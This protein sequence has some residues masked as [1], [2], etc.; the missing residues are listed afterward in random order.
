MKKN[1]FTLFCCFFA[2]WSFAC[3]DPMPAFYH[4]EPLTANS[5]FLIQPSG[6]HLNKYIR[7]D[8]YS[9]TTGK[10]IVIETT[11]HQQPNW[12][13][14]QILVQPT[15]SLILGDSLAFMM[16]YDTTITAFQTEA[17]DIKQRIRQAMINEHKGYYF[18][19]HYTMKVAKQAQAEFMPKPFYLFYENEYRTSVGRTSAGFGNTVA[20]EA[21][22]SISDAS[23][24]HLVEVTI[25]NTTL[26]Y[27]YYGDIFVVS[28]SSVCGSVGHNLQTD[29]EYT[30]DVR[31]L[32]WSGR[33]SEPCKIKFRTGIDYDPN[34]DETGEKQEAQINSFEAFMKDRW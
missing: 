25:G 3:C 5:V 31:L 16:S 13:D 19:L 4:A 29:T 9:K 34:N 20:I 21:N 18:S 24:L 33:Y 8:L 15:E 17:D 12:A 10:P 30:A 1:I 27:P 22:A 7:Y 6:F 23:K 14:A 2:L 11:T 28:G 26:Y 32:L